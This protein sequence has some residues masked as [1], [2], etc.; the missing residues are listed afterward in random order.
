MPLLPKN[1][2]RASL[3]GGYTKKRIGGGKSFWQ[4]SAEAIG[5]AVGAITGSPVAGAI[6][7]LAASGASKKKRMGRSISGRLGGKLKKK[8]FKKTKKF[9]KRI[10][11]MNKGVE[12][13]QEV[14]MVAKTDTPQK[15]EAVAIGHTS[16]PCRAMSVQLGRALLKYV[17][18]G[19]NVLVQDYTVPGEALGMVAGDNIR[20]RYYATMQ[21][22]ALSALNLVFSTGNSFEFLAS[23]LAENLESITYIEKVRWEDIEYLPVS[24]ARFTGICL[25]LHNA[26]VSGYT[27][28]SLKV[29]NRTVTVATDNEQGDVNHCP[30]SGKVYHLKGNN[31]LNLSNRKT[32]PG[33]GNTAALKANEVMLYEA[34]TQQPGSV[35][36]SGLE[37]YQP[38]YADS[39][40]FKVAECPKPSDVFNCVSSHKINLEPGQIKTSQLYHKI[41]LSFVQFVRII[42]AGKIDATFGFNERAGH[43]RVMHLEK[44]I[45]Q[46]VSSVAI[47]AEVQFECCLAITGKNRRYTIPITYQ[48]S[49]TEYEP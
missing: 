36:A 33:V 12:A 49:Y 21:A 22:T 2:R 25:S 3:Q 26:R 11:L 13:I 19:L 10:G 4:P 30:V 46:E 42:Y 27:K 8:G 45:G 14:R 40:F 38:L 17:F 29:Q 35:T 5:T 6:A 20:I 43:T 48:T 23:K 18:N 31:L 34:Y 44:V 47:A 9:D 28:S 37:R 16:M 32:L 41:S 15:Y 1:K 39:T 24:T 7:G